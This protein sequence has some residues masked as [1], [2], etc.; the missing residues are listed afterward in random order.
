MRVSDRYP[1]GDAWLMMDGNKDEWAVAFHGSSDL[2]SA[3]GI[4]KDRKLFTG[5]GG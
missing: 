1:D 4:Q 2:D 5:C 3:K